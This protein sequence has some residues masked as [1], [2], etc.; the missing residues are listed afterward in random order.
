MV[1]VV[2]AVKLNLMI[3]HSRVPDYPARETAQK[4][5]HDGACVE[6]FNQASLDGGRDA[7]GTMIRVDLT[8]Q[9][10]LDISFGVRKNC[11]DD[12]DVRLRRAAK[13]L[14]ETLIRSIKPRATNISF[15]LW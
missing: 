9:Q 14:R 5:S 8:I 12:Q 1:A 11:T 7:L 2:V 6:G 4:T 10:L 15:R 13:Q 3:W